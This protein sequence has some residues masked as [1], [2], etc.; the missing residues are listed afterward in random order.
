M[1]KLNGLLKIESQ[2]PRIRSNFKQK[3]FRDILKEWLVEKGR[4]V[5]ADLCYQRLVRMCAIQGKI[6]SSQPEVPLGHRALQTEPKLQE[7][8]GAENLW[9]PGLIGYSEE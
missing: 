9:T 4:A 3:T 8:N 7:M 1:R 2:K 6:S 5:N